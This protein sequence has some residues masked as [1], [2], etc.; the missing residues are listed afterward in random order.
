MLDFGAR[1]VGLLQPDWRVF[2]SESSVVSRAVDSFVLPAPDKR[3]PSSR[4][5]TFRFNQRLFVSVVAQ[6]G[7]GR[8][9]AGRRRRAAYQTSP[10]VAAA[11]PTAA[12]ASTGPGG[13]DS[14]GMR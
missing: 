13:I 12:A 10:A 14:D 6:P 4:I 3:K 9:S 2:L 1:S 8:E 5:F 11:A 7:D